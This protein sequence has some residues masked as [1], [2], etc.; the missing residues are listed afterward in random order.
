M[1]RESYSTHVLSELCE[2]F[3]AICKVKS[4]VYMYGVTVTSG[5][6]TVA[7]E[8]VASLKS[9]TTFGTALISQDN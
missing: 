5:S 9:G 2:A 8:F 1:W 7:M 3:V 6:V 4:G